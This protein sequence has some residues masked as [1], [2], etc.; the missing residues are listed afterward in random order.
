MINLRNL[1]ILFLCSILP[2][3]AYAQFVARWSAY[4]QEITDTNEAYFLA[5]TEQ[6]LLENRVSPATN[7]NQYPEVFDKSFHAS[8]YLVPLIPAEIDSIV[9][10]KPYA[11]APSR[12][13]LIISWNT[14]LD[15]F[16][17]LGM[18]PAPWSD[19]YHTFVPPAII[20]ASYYRSP[21]LKPEDASRFNSVM[22]KQ[23]AGALHG[24][25]RGNNQLE[26]V[27]QL[28]STYFGLLPHVRLDY[29]MERITKSAL[30]FSGLKVYHDKALTN[31]IYDVAEVLRKVN[32]VIT[33]PESTT[34]V[35]QNYTAVKFL[36]FENWK[37]ISDGGP[38]LWTSKTGYRREVR[39]M[40]MEFSNGK[41]IWFNLQEM[42]G[43]L[44]LQNTY[45]TSFEEVLRAERYL[46][47]Q[48]LPD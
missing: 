33:S 2:T 38:Y 21:F 4:V 45:F 8:F 34:W 24:Q 26:I 10:L 3:S 9:R 7:T 16:W 47:F 43:R 46:T 6:T 40:G 19:A 14:A 27:R 41:Q 37:P 44:K 29:L 12:S 39:S 31:E 32:Q 48:I 20:P 13:Q 17:V 11:K 30:D 25:L 35:I 36:I 28:D 5:R 15:S 42:S 18:T 23:M 22:L 1:Y